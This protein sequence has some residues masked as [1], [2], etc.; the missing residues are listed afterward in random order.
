MNSDRG[1]E[2]MPQEATPKA[3]RHRRWNRG[4][5]PRPVGVGAQALLRPGLLGSSSYVGRV[6]ALAV[7]LGVGAAVVALPGM[8]FADTAGSG[9]ASGSSVS[10]SSPSKGTKGTARSG[11]RPGR[12][13]AESAG[14]AGLGGAGLG[15]AAPAAADSEE[16][17]RVFCPVAVSCRARKSRLMVW[18]QEVPRRVLVGR[19]GPSLPVLMLPIRAPRA[20]ADRLVR[21]RRAHRPL[22]P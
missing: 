10:G 1:G 20:Q 6:G 4:A 21:W 5:R 8:A 9:G 22:A 2:L 14:G 7:S 17:G 11:A 13:G 19:S 15:G 16:A 3:L 12:A 18:V